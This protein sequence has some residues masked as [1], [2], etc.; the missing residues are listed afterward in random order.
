MTFVRDLI[1]SEALAPISTSDRIRL[2]DCRFDLFD[3]EKG[4]RDYLA[5]HLP[6]AVYADLEKDLSSEIRPGTGRHPLPEPASFRS[7]LERLGISNDTQVVAYD[8]SNGAV[9][10]R[11][12]WMLR[13]WFGH[14]DVA[15]LDGG[16]AAWQASGGPLGTGTSTVAPG[17]YSGTGN[18]AVVAS[19]A[20]IEARVRS[21]GPVRLVDARDPARFRGESE[22]IDTVAGH[23]PGATSMPL[24]LNLREDGRWRPASELGAVW[25]Q[26]GLG[27]EAGDTVAMCG[28][29]VTACHLILAAVLAGLPAPRLYVGSWSEWIRDPTRPIGP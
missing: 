16:I 5:G 11:F 19:T 29:G 7:A 22:P 17:R 20:E 1:S 21:G 12:W 3:T 13:F 2:V 25:A 27:G 23:V 18:D 10:A 9:A 15:V 26:S 28:S 4:R 6:G 8:G 24:S 14:D